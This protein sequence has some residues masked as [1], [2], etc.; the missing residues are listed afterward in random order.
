MTSWR[1]RGRKLPDRR[2]IFYLIFGEDAGKWGSRAQGDVGYGTRKVTLHE[3]VDGGLVGED[4][5]RF[6]LVTGQTASKKQLEI[7][8]NI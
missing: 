5:E 8:K 1:V 7:K 3:G 4:N 2:D 6:R